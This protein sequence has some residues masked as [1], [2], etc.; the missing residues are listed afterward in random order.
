VVVVSRMRKD[1]GGES[2]ERERFDV[3]AIAASQGET[4]LRWIRY[5]ISTRQV[6]PKA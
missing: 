6:H 4:Y 1:R 5:P 3:L 2:V